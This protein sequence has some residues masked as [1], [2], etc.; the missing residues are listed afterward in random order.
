MNEVYINIKDFGEGWLGRYLE[1][2]FNRDLISVDDLLGLIEDLSSDVEELE[3]R[4]R[5]L[6]EDIEQNYRP[7]PYKEQVEVYDSDFI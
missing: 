5:D 6:E 1:K 2:K 3:D 4:I 7:I